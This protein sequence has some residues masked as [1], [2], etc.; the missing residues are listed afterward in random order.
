MKKLAKEYKSK[1]V[2]CLMH[3]YKMS[4][5]EANR[6]IRISYLED[7]LNCYP[8]ETIH[9]DIEANADNVYYDYT[10]PRSLQM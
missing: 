4:E 7:S 9:D 8:E 3:K 5:I 2:E 6:A 10:H 1:V